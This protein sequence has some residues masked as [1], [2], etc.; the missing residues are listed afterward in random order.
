MNSMKIFNLVFTVVFC[1]LMS[2]IALIGQSK[3]TM[4]PDVFTEWRR[5]NDESICDDG[6]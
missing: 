1:F 2:S 4:T 5:I 3:K 6:K